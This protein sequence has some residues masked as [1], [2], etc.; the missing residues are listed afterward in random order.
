MRF[1]SATSESARYQLKLL[2]CVE[3]GGVL[4]QVEGGVHGGDEVGG[5]GVDCHLGLLVLGQP[6]GDIWPVP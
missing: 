3:M 1:I 6:M 2:F 5:V 4:A